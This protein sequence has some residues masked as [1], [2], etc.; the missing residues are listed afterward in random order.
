MAAP[1]RYPLE[2]RERAVRRWRSEQPR[3]PIADVAGELGMHPEVLGTW[4]RRDQADQGERTDLAATA[5]HPDHLTRVL[6]A[7]SLHR[8]LERARRTPA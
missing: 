4:I 8:A 7:R 6:A 2:L 3:R 1:P 5:E